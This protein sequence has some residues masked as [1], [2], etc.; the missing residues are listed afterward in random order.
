MR[1]RTWVCVSVRN[2][3]PK[4]YVHI[5]RRKHELRWKTHMYVNE[6]KIYLQHFLITRRLR[7]SCLSLRKNTCWYVSKMQKTQI[8]VQ[9]YA[10]YDSTQNWRII[11]PVRLWLKIPIIGWVILYNTHSVNLYVNAQFTMTCIKTPNI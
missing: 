3:W 7:G 4:W 8:F 9:F 6:S 1:G 10:T 5:R 11:T 2:M